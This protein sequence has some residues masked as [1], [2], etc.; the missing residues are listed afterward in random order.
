MR[1]TAE[2]LSFALLSPTLFSFPALASPVAAP[3]AGELAARHI[4]RTFLVPPPV[5]ARAYIP[6]DMN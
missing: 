4:T 3:E 2:T 5:T 6:G 1:F